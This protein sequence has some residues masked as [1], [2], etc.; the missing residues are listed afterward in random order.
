LN[1]YL[2]VTLILDAAIMRTL[3]LLPVSVPIRAL[4]TSS[5]CLKF[6]LVTL[7][8]VEKRR[9][10]GPGYDQTSPEESSGLYGQSLL[11]WLNRIIA[12]GA[13]QLIRP[14]DL[15]PIVKDMRSEVLGISFWR[16]W[17]DSMGNIAYT[18]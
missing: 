5:F 4:F 9:F 10:F 2:F 1:V 13:R 17:N 15:Y 12:L 11:W 18:L 3:W 8:A 16:I 7:E 14:A 6:V